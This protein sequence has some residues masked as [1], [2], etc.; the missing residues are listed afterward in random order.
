M[1]QFLRN[2]LAAHTIQILTVLNSAELGVRIWREARSKL[3]AR[4]VDESPIV[5]LGRSSENPVHVVPVSLAPGSVCILL[6]EQCVASYRAYNIVR[7]LP[8]HRLVDTTLVLVSDK[9]K[10]GPLFAA[11]SAHGSVFQVSTEK[12]SLGNLEPPCVV[13][14]SDTGI[15]RQISLADPIA[16]LVRLSELCESPLVRSKLSRAIFQRAGMVDSGLRGVARWAV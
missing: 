15:Q 2:P 4:A 11:A 16:G 10:S 7:D 14:T 1:R 6:S 5:F 9:G 12:A 3:Q 8:L 13:A